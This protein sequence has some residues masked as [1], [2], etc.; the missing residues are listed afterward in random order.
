MTIVGFYF[1]PGFCDL[2][3]FRNEESKCDCDRYNLC[4]N[5]W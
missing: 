2:A 3:Q 1:L 4:D 5:K